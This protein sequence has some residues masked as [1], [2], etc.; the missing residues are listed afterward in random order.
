MDTCQCTLESEFAPTYTPAHSPCMEECMDDIGTRLDGLMQ[1]HPLYRGR[2]QSALSRRTGVP[3][4]T[5]NR[6]LKN[7]SVPEMGTVVKL[8]EVFDVTCEWLLTGRGPKFIAELG[9]VGTSANVFHSGLPEDADQ[10]KFPLDVTKALQSALT[11]FRTGADV[12]SADIRTII[13]YALTPVESGNIARTSSADVT[14]HERAIV[15]RATAALKRT[16]NEHV[17]PIRE[18]SKKRHQS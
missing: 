6:I 11:A 10:Q 14:E 9:T 1:A 18:T 3:Q 13:W 15:E 8:A 5:I 16:G 12:K 17:E 7:Q 4:P 2:G